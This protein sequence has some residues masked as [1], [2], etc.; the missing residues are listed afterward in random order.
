MNFE[1]EDYLSR[2]GETVQFLNSTS[3]HGPPS[4]ALVLGT[5]QGGFAEKLAGAVRIAYAEIP[6]LPVSRVAGH[7]GEFALA[8]HAGKLFCVLAGRVHLYEG[9]PLQQVVFAVRSLALWGVRNFVLTN[10]A[11]ALNPDFQPGDVMIIRDHIN[12]M[13]ANPLCGPNLDMLGPRFPDMS[14]AYCPSLLELARTS[15]KELG[16]VLKEGV[17]VGQLGPNYET[18]AEISMCRKLGADA[19]GMPTVPEVIALN[20]MGKRMLALSCITNAGAGLS[21]CPPSHKRLLDVTGRM[22]EPLRRLLLKIIE[23][24]DKE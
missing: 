17:Y 5:G 2:L 19:V 13:G 18:P 1:P 16:L 20:H 11:G 15:G 24:V 8:R 10:P 21:S 14:Q 4:T 3:R 9:L 12:L 6:N 23:K 22:S 7:S